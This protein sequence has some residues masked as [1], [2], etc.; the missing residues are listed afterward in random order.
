MQRKPTWPIEPGDEPQGLIAID[1]RV[2]RGD[3]PSH[4]PDRSAC[5]RG[6][7]DA[8]PHGPVTHD[9]HSRFDQ[10]RRATPPGLARIIAAGALCALLAGA[11]P[12]TALAQQPKPEGEMR[13]ALYVTLSPQ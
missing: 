5:W 10:E 2:A 13:W 9:L 4:R 12:A 3:G 8:L 1:S 6:G 7:D 11:L